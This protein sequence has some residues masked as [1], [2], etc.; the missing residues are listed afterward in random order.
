MLGNAESVESGAPLV[1]HSVES[2]KRVA[3][4][5]TRNGGIAQTGGYDNPADAMNLEQAQE[6]LHGFII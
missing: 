3:G 6:L 2:E 5:R 4:K 1:D